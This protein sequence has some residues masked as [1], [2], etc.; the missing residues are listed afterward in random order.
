MLGE[1]SLFYQL[2][3]KHFPMTIDFW[4]RLYTGKRSR[5]IPKS[6]L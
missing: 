5:A 4:A 1:M 2:Q 3:N 6:E